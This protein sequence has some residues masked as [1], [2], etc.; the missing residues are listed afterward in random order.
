MA[1]VNQTH[2]IGE[3][4]RPVKISVRANTAFLAACATRNSAPARRAARRVRSSGAKIASAPRLG[5][6]RNVHDDA[7][8]LFVSAA[9][10][11]PKNARAV[12]DASAPAEACV[13]AAGDFPTPVP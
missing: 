7:K 10:T 1:S 5:T 8:R 9:S 3:V 2:R 6:V 4:V 13:N 12:A 11:L